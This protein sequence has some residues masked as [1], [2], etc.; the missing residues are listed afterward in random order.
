MANMNQDEPPDIHRAS[1]SSSPGDDMLS[2]LIRSTPEIQEEPLP[3]TQVKDKGKEGEGKGVVKEK[4]PTIPKVI[5]SC[6]YIF[7]VNCKI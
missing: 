3:V 2:S 6:Y 5:F 7:H 4:E 1:I